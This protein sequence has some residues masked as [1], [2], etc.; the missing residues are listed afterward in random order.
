LNHTL[1][2]LAHGGLER[3]VLG[4]EVKVQGRR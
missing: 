1:R 4:R 2:Q 3:R